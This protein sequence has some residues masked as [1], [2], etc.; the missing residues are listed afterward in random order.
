MYRWALSVVTIASLIL[1]GASALAVETSRDVT[2]R[3]AVKGRQ[4]IAY[5][6]VPANPAAKRY[7]LIIA[8]HGGAGNAEGY[9]QQSRIFDK[10]EQAGFMVVC[11]QATTLPGGGNHRVWNSG[12]E[13]ALPS[14]HAD[15][16]AFTEALIREIGAKY[17][18]DSKRIY[19]TGFSNGGQMSYRAALELSQTFA[20]IAP[21]S[22]ARLA[23]ALRPGRA[24]PV[25]H[26]HGTAD[27][28]YPLQGGLGAYS[29]G[30]TPH[31]PIQAARA[32]WAVFNGAR[33]APQSI[34]REGW[35]SELYAGRAPV[36]LVLV[37]GMGHQIAGGADNH[38]PDQPMRDSP[39]AVAMAIKFFAAHPMP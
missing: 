30:P 7:P 10:G 32:E 5:L 17:P 3:L 12:A 19:A 24:V 33:A 38:L 31:G 13:Y 6:H 23:G 16:V 25:L 22:G 2:L 4:R 11:P 8:Y 36:E 26:I 15:D 37:D 9:I 27:G 28:Y 21:M 1:G 39:D 35:E 29:L 20:A 18:L 14:R 34:R